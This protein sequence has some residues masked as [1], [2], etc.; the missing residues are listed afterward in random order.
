MDHPVTL[1][2][3]ACPRIVVP[4]ARSLARE[5]VPVV[6]GSLLPGTP[7]IRSR[8]L[9]EFRRLTPPAL[10]AG[11]FRT[12]LLQL[13]RDHAVDTLIPTG[14]E[15]LTALAL[16]ES[17]W[18][19]H[20]HVCSPPW[21][22]A[23]RV[24]DKRITLDAAERCGIPAPRS[25]SIECREDINRIAPDFPL[26]AIIKPADKARDNRLRLRR[27]DERGDLER[28]LH[29]HAR[30]EEPWLLQ[31]HVAGHGLGI[32]VLMHNG[33]PIVSFQHRRLKEYPV[34]GG[35]AARCV[36]ETVD[37]VLE[38]Q[39]VDLLTALEW[40]GVAMVEY[41]RD[42]ASGRTVLMEVNGRYWGSVALPLQC[43]VALP[44]YEWQI[45]HGI[46]PEP[47]AYRPGRRMRWL[48]G[49]LQR[50]PEAAG[51]AA[52]GNIPLR[53]AAHD[54]L[55]FFTDFLAPRTR[56]ALWQARDARPALDDLG[57][58]IRMV[59]AQVLRK[60]GKLLLP[61]GGQQA[62][63]RILALGARGAWH[64]RRLRRNGPPPP[65]TAERLQQVR[66]VLFLCHG[67]IASS[68]AAAA[69]L[70]SKLCEAG[71]ARPE[72]HSAGVAALDGNKA[73]PDAVSAAS[74]LGIGL[75]EHRA[76]RVTAELVDQADA[77][78]VMDYMNL[79]RLL[80]DFPRA[81][82]KTWL[83]GSLHPDYTRKP[84][85]SAEIRDPYG[86]GAEAAEACLDELIPCLQALLQK[87]RPEEQPA[88]EPAQH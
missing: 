78:F 35:V 82:G 5:G 33:E 12:E 74:R 21:S 27:L 4:V 67:N 32:E 86:R 66:S 18:R 51:A 70:R 43:G 65:P 69:W 80:R 39:A 15:V 9:R 10:S 40:E 14:D 3:G 54:A 88:A 30:P 19:E 42:P 76:Q 20:L 44:W 11:R 57:G 83:L 31:E 64:Y 55:T 62:L 23:Q 85:H 46:D 8:T 1:L 73:D 24:L 63:E 60:T 25:H 37:P 56:D 16:E 47:A 36:A 84:G 52:A 48:A 22:I 28:F 34:T 41:R 53:Q 45:A 61:Q 58:A 7:P 29:A 72:V 77:I 17:L 26:P 71:K 79:V 87:M 50:L 49:D 75:D 81:Q 68:A 59:N 6:A 13:I 2:L 38:Q